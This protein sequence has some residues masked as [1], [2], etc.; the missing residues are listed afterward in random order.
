MLC[1]LLCQ[2]RLVSLSL[3]LYLS[4][5]S[6]SSLS[7]SLSFLSLL[8]LSSLSLSLSPFSLLSLSLSPFSLSSLSPLSLSLSLSF[9][10]PLSLSLHDTQKKER[11]R[12]LFSKQNIHQLKINCYSKHGNELAPNYIDIISV[13]RM[14]QMFTSHHKP[15]PMQSHDECLAV[16]DHNGFCP[17]YPML[18]IRLHQAPD[19]VGAQQYVC[20]ICLPCNT[21]P[22]SP[23]LPLFLL[24]PTPP[25]SPPH[26]I[27]P[28]EFTGRNPH[29]YSTQ[30]THRVLHS[31]TLP[32]PQPSSVLPSNCRP[33]HPFTSADCLIVVWL[34]LCSGLSAVPICPT[35]GPYLEVVFILSPSKP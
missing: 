33:P 7:L 22:L 21:S 13:P 14:A 20:F 11:E 3:P 9:L 32:F 31:F 2:I 23:S 5:L 34:C 17:L 6:L 25:P 24:P 15:T 4:L 28:S 26:P 19:N 8:S 16:H 29:M 10:S 1:V 12:E 35:G 30:H 27:L 18:P